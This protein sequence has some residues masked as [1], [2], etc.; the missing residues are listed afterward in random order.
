MNSLGD[1]G[2]GGGS[3]IKN[4]GIT[5]LGF[6]SNEKPFIWTPGKVYK[7]KSSAISETVAVLEELYKN[8]SILQ[9]STTGENNKDKISGNV[10]C[11][12]LEGGKFSNVPLTIYAGMEKTE[13]QQDG[14]IWF[15]PREG[16]E[17]FHFSDPESGISQKAGV[18]NALMGL[19]HELGHVWLKNAIPQKYEWLQSSPLLSPL[20]NPLKEQTIL[21]YLESGTVTQVFRQAER[22]FYYRSATFKTDGPFSTIKIN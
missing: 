15:N 14:S 21:T 11:D 10:L 20:G 13:T 2:G 5:I 19:V 17:I 18:Q 6:E 9:I 8:G 7:G 4:S 1:A 16:L 22:I 3:N 12:F